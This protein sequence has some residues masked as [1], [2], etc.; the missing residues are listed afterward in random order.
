MAG[1]PV[2]MHRSASELHIYQKFDVGDTLGSGGFSVVYKARELNSGEI[3]A[4]KVIDLARYS[5]SDTT[6]KR[7]IDIL[8]KARHPNII[9]LRSVFFTEKSVFMVMEY[10]PGGELLA[11][12][13]KQVRF[14][15]R[16]AAHIIKQLL[17]AV[18]YLHTCGVVHRDIKLENILLTSRRSI[19]VKLADFGLS[20][21]FEHEPLQTM[22]GSPQYVSPEVLAMAESRHGT[23]PAKAYTP[24]VD[25]WSAGVV[26]FM[27]LSGYSPFDDDD[28]HKVFQKIRRGQ[29]DVDDPIWKRISAP[30]KD[31]VAGMLMVNPKKRLTAQ[32]ALEHPWLMFWE[33]REATEAEQRAKAAPADTPK[34]PA[35]AGAPSSKPRGEPRHIHAH[36]HSGGR[37]A[38]LEPTPQQTKAKEGEEAQAGNAPKAPTADKA[39]QQR[40]EGVNDAEAGQQRAHSKFN[41]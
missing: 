14:P 25:V 33:R 23:V 10:A 34:P 35:D 36:S 13:R 5:P 3:V 38:S 9:Q 28:D 15:E 39:V 29:C 2:Q 24:A 40:A 41:G 19:D 31:L 12:I 32:Q 7:E 6:L 26:L 16:Q 18:A 30:A 20:K 27:L 8:T 17:G 4:I 22:C 11:R 21:C 37:A 1:Q